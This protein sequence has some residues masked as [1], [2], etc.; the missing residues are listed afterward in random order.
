MGRNRVAKGKY[1]ETLPGLSRELV[2]FRF[3]NA[4]FIPLLKTSWMVSFARHVET[5][6]RTGFV[7]S[8]WVGHC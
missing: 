2:T 5:E 6:E 3:S 7:E 1:F 4:Q 8:V